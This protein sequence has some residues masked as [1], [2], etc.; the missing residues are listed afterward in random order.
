M[1][2]MS[3]VKARAR[4]IPNQNCLL[5]GGGGVGRWGCLALIGQASAVELRRSAA[6]T[7]PHLASFQGLL[8]AV[9]T[10]PLLVFEGM[11]NRK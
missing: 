5:G 6:S 3:S 2:S 11:K 1:L 7:P 8:A 4:P 10:V 9:R